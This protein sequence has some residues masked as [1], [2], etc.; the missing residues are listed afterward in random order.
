MERRLTTASVPIVRY[1]DHLRFVY[2]VE[3][4]MRELR[5]TENEDQGG[6]NNGQPKPSDATPASPGESQQNPGHK[7]GGSRMDP[8]PQQSGRPALRQEQNDSNDILETSLTI[9]KTSR[10]FR[11]LQNSTTGMEVRERSTVWTA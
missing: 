11:R 5:R 8:P 3:S 7:G 10:A 2:E 4:R 6:D 9:Q 1:Y